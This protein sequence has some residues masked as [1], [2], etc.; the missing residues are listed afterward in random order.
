VGSG[1][2]PLAPHQNH[3]QLRGPIR[4]IA[5]LAGSQTGSQSVA[6]PPWRSPQCPV[7]ATARTR[8][9]S[10]RRRTAAV[11]LG[12]GPDVKRI[13]RKVTGRTKQEVRDKLKALHAE[14]DRGLRTSSTYTAGQAVNDWL[15]GGL[16]GRTER[17]PSI[18][19]EALTPLLER[20]GAKPLRE[21][22]D[23]LDELTGEHRGQPDSGQD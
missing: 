9:T 14:L 23:K 12:S 21:L 4:R 15:E 13:R 8:S 10:T 2:D 17:T 7:A 11:S 19:Q 18:Y 5:R 16:P 1:F 3:H 22:L 20:I 6:L